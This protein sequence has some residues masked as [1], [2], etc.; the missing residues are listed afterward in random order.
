MVKL[1]TW[2]KDKNYIY[3]IASFIFSLILFLSLLAVRPIMHRSLGN[4][5]FLSLHTF[6][7]F[8]SILFAFSI[9]TLVFHSYKQNAN[10]RSMVLAITFF[11]TGFID[12][13]HTL[14]YKGMPDF[15]GPSCVY[16]ATAFWVIARS[17]M[18]IGFFIAMLTDENKT[19]K[20]SRWVML[21]L[22]TS[23]ILWVFNT[24]TFRPH[25]LPAFYIEG[26]GLTNQ[27]LVAEF[28]IILLQ[29]ITAALSLLEYRRTGN[30]IS[31]IF[32]SALIINIFS[33]LSFALYTGIYDLYNLMGHI[34]KILTYSIMFNILFV[35]NIRLPY[36]K[37]N[38]AKQLLKNQASNLELE[39]ERAKEQVINANRRLYRDMEHA[40]EIQQSMLPE[41]WLQLDGIEFYSALIPCEKLSGDF[42]NIFEIDRD[43]I[44]VYLVDVS[45]HGISSAIMTIFADRTIL[46][47]KL[48][49]YKQQLLLSPSAVLEDLFKLYNTTKF[50]PEMYLLMFY[51]V[52]NKKTRQFTYA[53]AGL[54]TQ[55]FIISGT[56]LIQLEVE[57]AFPICKMGEY[58][59][60]RY[61]DGKLTLNPGDKIFLYSDGLVEAANREGVPFGMDRLVD[62]LISNS[63][64]SS[65]EIFYEVFDRFSCFV[66][67]KKLKDDV[68]FVLMHVL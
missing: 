25:L 44:G 24:V 1:S 28:L 58:Y 9:F 56:S 29:G 7:E 35:Y 60:P 41:R 64:K 59:R 4:G 51:G 54:N 43:N 46:T 6:L 48:I 57:D 37:L 39:V 65:E 18:A 10:L 2:L 55:P 5:A 30:K 32:A 62:I 11:I 61:T 33:G 31:V 26:Q 47:N 52:Y 13:F 42:Y 67:D 63:L 34:Y 23:V 3:P 14:C 8:L 17:V 12:I 15:F 68:T 38:K 19:A 40:R 45:G 27:K 36:E 22:A 21:V 66:L 20:L 50:P 16:R 53:S 49:T